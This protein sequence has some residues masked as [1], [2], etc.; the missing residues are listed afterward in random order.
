MGK[1]NAAEEQGKP[2][3]VSG[4]SGMKWTAVNWDGAS[5]YCR[6]EA[7]CGEQDGDTAAADGIMEAA[8]WPPGERERNT[9]DHNRDREMLMSSANSATCT[10]LWHMHGKS[11]IP[12]FIPNWLTRSHLGSFLGRG[13]WRG[14]F[15]EEQ[16]QKILQTWR[17]QWK[18]GVQEKLVTL[19]VQPELAGKNWKDRKEAGGEIL[20]LRVSVQQTAKVRRDRV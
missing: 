9:T 17:S 14:R 11:E 2:H 6:Q 5:Y 12:G 1:K 7:T 19:A 15:D 20:K 16:K 8:I 18:P 4:G 10:V 13:G 3:K